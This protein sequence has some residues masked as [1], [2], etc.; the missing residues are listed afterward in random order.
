MS[1]LELAALA[2]GS[3]FVVAAYVKKAKLQKARAKVR[4]KK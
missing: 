4:A 1:L 2:L 3:T